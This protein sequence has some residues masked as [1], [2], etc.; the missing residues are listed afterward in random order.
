MT[1]KK[2]LVSVWYSVYQSKPGG[3]KGQETL[4]G[5]RGLNSGKD[6]YTVCVLSLLAV[7]GLPRL[8][9]WQSSNALFSQQL[10]IN[11]RGLHSSTGHVYVLRRSAG[12]SNERLIP[13][14]ICML[15]GQWLIHP[16]GSMVSNM[17]PNTTFLI[18][19]IFMGYILPLSDGTVSAAVLTGPCPAST[20]S[21]FQYDFCP[22]HPRMTPWNELPCHFRYISKNDLGFTVT[23]IET[24]HGMRWALVAE[25][26]RHLSGWRIW[27]GSL[28]DNCNYAVTQCL[29]F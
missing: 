16:Q 2:R 20:Q 6:G 18:G 8:W 4:A 23:D 25:P 24:I 9:P 7:C 12:I 1:L 3:N 27:E 5:F 15:V 28:A 17:L 22:V 29:S 14:C 19:K 10:L 21:T 26:M 11:D 13:V